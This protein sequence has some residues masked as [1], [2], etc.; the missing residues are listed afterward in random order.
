MAGLMARPIVLLLA[1]ALA[2]VAP[3]LA[4]AKDGQVITEIR[5]EG[6]IKVESVAIRD[7][8]PIEVGDRF[9]PEAVRQAIRDIYRLGH[10]RDIWVEKEVD[11]AGL[12]LIISA[13]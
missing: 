10:F 3:A 2:I 7:I 8:I 13:R 12:A 6:N 11:D 5:V 4:C 9:R 1:V